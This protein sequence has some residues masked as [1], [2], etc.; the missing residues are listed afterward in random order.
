[1]PSRPASPGLTLAIV[2]LATFMLLLDVTVVTVAL[3]DIR[4]DLDANFSSIQWVLDA[5]TLMLAALLLPA[6]SLGDLRGRRLVFLVGTAVFT[7]ASLA[8]AFAPDATVLNL[9]RVVQGAGGAAMFAT[10]LPL[11]STAF[12]GPERAGAI[13]AF[14]ATIGAA[15]AVGP[16]VGGAIT[17][18]LSWEW[19]FLVNVPTGLVVLVVGSRRL[20]ETRDPSGRRIDVPGTLLAILG[21]LTLVYAVVRGNA[22]GW[23][24]A[25]IVGGFGASAVL[26]GAFVTVE[27]RSAAPMVPLGLL[28]VP[29]LAAAVVSVLSIASGLFGMFLVLVIWLQAGLDQ[30]PFTVGLEFLPLTVV[31]FVASAWTGRRLTAVLP[32]P[33]LLGGGLLL[34]TIGLVLIALVDAGSAWTALVP[35][36][37]LCGLGSGLV[38][39]TAATLSLSSVEPARAGIASALVNLAREVGTAIGIA[40]LGSVFEAR[41][42]GRLGDGVGHLAAAGGAAPSAAVR[43]ALA[44]GLTTAALVGATVTAVGTVATLI[45]LRTHRGLAA[46]RPA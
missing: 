6:A 39:P 46:A 16:L 10:A 14:A 31:S 33:V 20:P 41:V 40:A 2:C 17:S 1:M 4:A 25:P 36:L 8:C 28:R 42:V 21:L 26:L 34:T 43:E 38:N 3:P 19:I 27:L 12:P 45:L 22:E 11:I 30:G 18:G 23:G 35:G 13:G 29:A 24:S 7:A 32:V 44:S 5:Y 15:I 9:S 37:A